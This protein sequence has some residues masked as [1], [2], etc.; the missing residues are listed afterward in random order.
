[1]SCVEMTV[2]TPTGGRPQA[3][4][5]C[6]WY[7]ARM[8]THYQ[9]PVQWIVVDDYDPPSFMHALNN[10]EVFPAQLTYVRPARRWQPGDNTLAASLLDAIPLVLGEKIA[11]VEDDDWYDASYLS[12]AAW[13]LDT[14]EI[15]GAPNTIY[16]HIPSRQWRAM[17]NTSHAS[18]CQTALRRSML[19]RLADTCAHDAHHIDVR[20]WEGHKPSTPSIAWRRRGAQLLRSL[21]V[22][23]KGLPGRP[24]IGVGHRPQ[25]GDGWRSDPDGAALR[26]L[27]GEDASLYAQFQ[28]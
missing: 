5:L 25:P 27:I 12:Y 15:A 23:M 3:L 24:G 6:A 4:R 18:L 21:V 13:E 9:R 20:L 1:M 16:Y 8:V 19:P 17:G 7:V 14:V 2:I 10:V 26:G 11:I 28:A 22:G